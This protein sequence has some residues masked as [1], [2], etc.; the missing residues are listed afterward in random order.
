MWAVMPWAARDSPTSGSCQFMHDATLERYLSA[1]QLVADH[2]VIGAGPL[3][4]FSD[5]G[6]SGFELSAINRIQQ[7]YRAHGFRIGAGEGG[8]AFGLDRYARAFFVAWRYRFRNEL[9][10]AEATLASLAA[11]EKTRCPL[12]RAHLVRHELGKQVAAAGRDH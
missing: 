10:L 9:G 4:F 7:I 3:R 2:A 6:D 5:P 1:A 11:E 8:E 12:R